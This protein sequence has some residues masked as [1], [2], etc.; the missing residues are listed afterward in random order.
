M[1]KEVT[2]ISEDLWIIYDEDTKSGI[3]IKIANP[4]DIDEGIIVD[5]SHAKKIIHQLKEAIDSKVEGIRIKGLDL[6]DYAW[7]EGSE[8]LKLLE[9]LEFDFRRAKQHEKSIPLIGSL[10]EAKQKGERLENHVGI[11][12]EPGVG[13]TS[14]FYRFMTGEFKE[15]VRPT[16]GI[17]VQIKKVQ[18]NDEVIELKIWDWGK[19]DI[20]K[21]DHKVRLSGVILVFDVTRSHTM[22]EI[23]D[24]W[25]K[26]YRRDDGKFTIPIVLA[27]NKMDLLKKWFFV[28]DTRLDLMLQ[29]QLSG[30]FRCSVKTGKNINEI[31]HLLASEIMSRKMENHSN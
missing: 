14:L 22:D 5:G 27:G 7:V 28:L 24:K 30:F 23:Y 1:V 17:D 2:E 6:E 11:L 25:L 15:K 20:Y 31:L 13:K 4:P 12:G 9:Y 26:T 3:T 18:I 16:M 10:Q 8:M 29:N 19:P 21:L